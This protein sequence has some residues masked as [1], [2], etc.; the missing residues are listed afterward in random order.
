MMVK[1]DD[2]A[3]NYWSSA[4]PDQKQFGLLRLEM[5]TLMQCLTVLCDLG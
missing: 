3:S 2:S 1:I 4:E 5:P